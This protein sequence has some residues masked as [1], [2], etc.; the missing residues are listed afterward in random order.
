MRVLVTGVAGF[1]G[2]H[3]AKRLLD[4]AHEVVGIDDL[5]SGVMDNVD[6]RAAFHREDIRS[7]AIYPLFEGIE[8]VFHLAA[9]NCLA[10]C[11][12]DPVETAQVNVAGTANVLE[13]AH[14]AGVRKL[15]YAD[16]SAEY[17]GIPELPSSVERVAPL[18]VYARSKR[19]GAMFCEAYQQ[20]HGLRLTTLRYFNVYGPAQDWRRTIPP[21]MSAF[22]LTLL[23]GERPV[24]YGTGEKRRDFVYVDDV[25]EFNLLALRDPR[26]DG[27]AYN[28]GSG[29]NHSI[30]EIFSLIEQRLKTGLQP[31][32]KDDLPGEAQATLADIQR[33]RRLGWQ[34][35]VDLREGIERSI[36]YLKNHVLGGAAARSLSDGSR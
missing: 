25:T 18:S 2:S 22:I 20:F 15:I 7:Q 4:E 24:I 29:A 31:V 3:L 10:D 21:V 13:A 32:R 14:Q 16:T 30:N 12:R 28:V 27:Q 5:S 34:P 26:T 33:E 35:R 17:E 19:A 6:P 11:L 9:K 36:A 8:A 23:Q 1:I